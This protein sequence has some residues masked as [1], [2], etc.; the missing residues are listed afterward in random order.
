MPIAPLPTY[1]CNILVLHQRHA[2]S[3]RHAFLQDQAKE[4]MKA[5]Y[6]MLWNHGTHLFL[7][8][9]YKACSEFYKA[10][11]IYADDATKPVVAR[12]LALAHLATQNLDRYTA[13]FDLP[14][15]TRKRPKNSVVDMD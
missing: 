13:P 12:Q 7:K 3:S 4:H 9:S 10:A 6:T 11:L 2:C 8:K 5:L 14:E 15:L 1:N